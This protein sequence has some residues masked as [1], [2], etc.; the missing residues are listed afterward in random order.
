VL[1]LSDPNLK[2]TE[3]Q[4]P[5]GLRKP[6]DDVGHTHIMRRR[7]VRL[8]LKRA[9]QRTGAL[10]LYAAALALGVLCGAY[11]SSP[12]WQAAAH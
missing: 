1:Y 10:L 6:A 8:R 5:S 2:P 9:L 11:M 4:P 3:V 7:F 12:S